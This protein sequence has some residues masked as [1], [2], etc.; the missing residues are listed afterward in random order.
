ML[1]IDAVS[2]QEFTGLSPEGVYE[3][4]WTIAYIHIGIDPA[5]DA[6]RVFTDLLF[7]G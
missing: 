1:L 2:S 7:Y 4:N 6:Y 5:R 3:A